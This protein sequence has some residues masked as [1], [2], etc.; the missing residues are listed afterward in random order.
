MGNGGKGEIVLIGSQEHC[1]AKVIFEHLKKL[2]DLGIG[3]SG[4]GG[5]SK[6]KG[7][8]VVPRVLRRVAF[9]PF[10]YV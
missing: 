1:S 4:V 6:Y 2:R 9:P 7:P 8:E 5:N 10:H 3:A